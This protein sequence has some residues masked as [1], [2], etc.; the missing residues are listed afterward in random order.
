MIHVED[1]DMELAHAPSV[2]VRGA[3]DTD[4]KHL[5]HLV[6]YSRR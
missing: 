6:G 1:H 5:N 2:E 3:Q 4:G